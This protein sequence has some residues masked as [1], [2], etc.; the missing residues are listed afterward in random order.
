MFEHVQEVEILRDIIGSIRPIGMPRNTE[1]IHQ[2]ETEV[3]ISRLMTS[4]MRPTYVA[5]ICPA[6]VIGY[7]EPRKFSRIN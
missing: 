6:T 7:A 3:V 2:I 5:R 4:V 1:H